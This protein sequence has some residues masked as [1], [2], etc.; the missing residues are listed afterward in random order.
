MRSEEQ[1]SLNDRNAVWEPDNPY[2]RRGRVVLAEN[3]T[4]CGCGKSLEGQS[5]IQVACNHRDNTTNPCPVCR[6]TK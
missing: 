2:H 3:D 6:R 1:K 5:I 4:C